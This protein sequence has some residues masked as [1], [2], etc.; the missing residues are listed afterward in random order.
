MILG[1]AFQAS[2]RD[3]VASRRAS[4]PSA[5]LTV[6]TNGTILGVQR[7]TSA[8]IT[9]LLHHGKKTRNNEKN[10]GYSEVRNADCKLT[11]GPVW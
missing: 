5:T 3:Q 6:A 9:E 8:K 7:D 4:A 2:R 11:G 10:Y 1:L